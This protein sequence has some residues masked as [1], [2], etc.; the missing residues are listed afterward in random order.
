MRIVFCSPVRCN[1]RCSSCLS[2]SNVS[3]SLSIFFQRLILAVD[4]VWLAPRP[5]EFWSPNQTYALENAKSLVPWLIGLVVTPMAVCR[6]P[7]AWILIDHLCTPYLKPTFPIT[8]ICGPLVFSILVPK[9]VKVTPDDRTDPS[10]W[11]TCKYDS[12]YTE[13]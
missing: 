9:L 3:V 1:W 5:Y 2:Q 4:S 6:R 7:G 10:N 11:F 12:V 13:Q 8:D